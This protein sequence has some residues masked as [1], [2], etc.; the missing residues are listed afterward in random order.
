M[1]D[2]GP[3]DRT[4]GRNSEILDKA[5]VLRHARF[6]GRNLQVIDIESAT[7]SKRTYEIDLD[8]PNDWV[9]LVRDKQES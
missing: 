8:I 5:K 1:L 9:L 7:E 6:A 4:F 3:N 2:L